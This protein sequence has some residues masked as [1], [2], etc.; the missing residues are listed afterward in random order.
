LSDLPSEGVDLSPIP[1]TTL[2]TSDTKPVA[3]T[4]NRE[5]DARTALTRGLA[6]YLLTLK[7]VAV[8]GRE[9]RFNKVFSEWADAESQAEYPSAA[10]WSQEEGIY[11]AHSFT[12]TLD[13]RYKIGTDIDGPYLLKLAEFTLPIIV[14]IWAVDRAMRRELMA[15]CE[16]A[17]N[18]VD[19]MYG[20]RL[21]LPHYFNERATYSMERMRYLDDE[22]NVDRRYRRASIFV[23]AQVPVAKAV[24]YMPAKPVVKGAGSAAPNVNSGPLVIGPNTKVF[25]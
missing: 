14:D 3:Y 25:S 12:P 16:A 2:V 15:M 18:P 24:R 1:G 23:Q 17:F 7:A 9:V 22:E 11:D 13:P 10:V 4:L 6:E 21:D 19:F 20:F 8:G 5:T